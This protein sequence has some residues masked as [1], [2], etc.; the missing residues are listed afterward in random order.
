[1][2]LG[3]LFGKSDYPEANKIEDTAYL[4]RWPRESGDFE[5]ENRG[6]PKLVADIKRRS[7]PII[8]RLGDYDRTGRATEFLIQVGTLPCGKLQFAAVGVSATEP[9]LHA[10][11]SVAKP[12][13]P[14]IMPLGAWQALLKGPGPH[15]VPTWACGDHGSDARTDL[16]VSASDGQ[17]HVK[18]REFSCPP[19]SQAEKLVKETAQ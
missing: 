1:M 3:P 2:D 18:D 13:A 11:T 4:V 9:H 17:I 8:M 6:D 14:L 15:T 12:D 16:V 7:A 19:D 5:R 10:L